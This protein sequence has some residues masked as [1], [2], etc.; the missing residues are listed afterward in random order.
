MSPDWRRFKTI[1]TD[2][3]EPTYSA[4]SQRWVEGATF[5]VLF[6]LPASA[7]VCPIGREDDE[8]STPVCRYHKLKCIDRPAAQLLTAID[9]PISRQTKAGPRLSTPEL[10]EC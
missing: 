6:V 10:F 5:R 9:F 2:V 1:G 8:T 3:N 4:I 7:S